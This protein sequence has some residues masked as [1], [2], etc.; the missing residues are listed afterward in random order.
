MA[1]LLYS[2]KSCLQTEGMA[3]FFVCCHAGSAHPTRRLP[4]GLRPPTLT[5][6][7]TGTSVSKPC[8]PQRDHRPSWTASVP[9]DCRRGS[10]QYRHTSILRT[11]SKGRERR[12]NRGRQVQ[13]PLPARVDAAAAPRPLQPPH[14]H[15]WHAIRCSNRSQEGVVKL[16]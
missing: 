3:I 2:F 9:S 7:P 1:V 8:A 10:R 13:P 4:P 15:L 6:T 5:P 14:D 11:T 12:A 16:K